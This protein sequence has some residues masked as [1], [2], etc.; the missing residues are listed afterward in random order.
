MSDKK[1]PP[2][3]AEHALQTCLAKNGERIGMGATIA[4]QAE[5]IRLQEDK[6]QRQAAELHALKMPGAALKQAGVVMPPPPYMPGVEPESL[7]DYERGE[8]QGRCDM[9]AAVA[10]LNAPR[11]GAPEALGITQ[12]QIDRHTTTAWE[13]P[14]QSLVVL[15]SSLKRLADKNAAAPTP[16]PDHAENR[17][18]GD[19]YRA[20]LYDEVWQKARDM[21]YGN[22]TEALTALER[23]GGDERCFALD[24]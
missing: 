2:S 10:R 8:A 13:C 16:A 4:Q 5:L 11:D 22:V 20:E 23:Q 7:S 14:P 15:V 1:V 19:K 3:V 18:T 9:W 21:G 12:E 24:N 6:I 17:T